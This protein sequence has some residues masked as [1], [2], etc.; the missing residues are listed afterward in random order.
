MKLFIILLFIHYTYASQCVTTTLCIPN[1]G[2]TSHCVGDST[3]TCNGCMDM[4]DNACLDP[5]MVG[6]S[7]AGFCDCNSGSGCSNGPAPGPSDAPPEPPPITINFDSSEYFVC[8]GETVNVNFDGLYNIYEVDLNNYNNYDYSFNSQH[9]IYSENGP[10]VY[11]I[12]N[13]GTTVGNTRYFICTL[14]PHRKFKTTCTAPPEPPP[15]DTCASLGC[16]NTQCR[17][18]NICLDRNPGENYCPEGLEDCGSGPTPEDTCASLGCSNTQCRSGNLC[19]DNMRLPDTNQCPEGLEDCGSGPSPGPPSETPS[20]T[21]SCSNFNECISDSDN[22]KNHCGANGCT[23]FLSSIGDC[24]A[25]C[26]SND[27]ESCQTVT[28]PPP[29]KKYTNEVCSGDT[30][31]YSG[32]CESFC[33]NNINETCYQHADPSDCASTLTC[34]L[35]T[36]SNYVCQD[37]RLPD[38]STCTEDSECLS[39]SCTPDNKCCSLNPSNTAECDCISSGS[40]WDGK[41]KLLVGSCS[42]PSDC[43]SNI[44]HLTQCVS[45]LPNNP[46]LLD[47]ATTCEL[48]Q[49][50]S[51]QTNYIEYR[52]AEKSYTLENGQFNDPSYAYPSFLNVYLIQVYQ[53]NVAMVQ[54]DATL[55]YIT[56]QTCNG[57]Y[58]VVQKKLPYYPTTLDILIDGLQVNNDYFRLN[59]IPC[60]DQL[61]TYVPSDTSIR[62]DGFFGNGHVSTSTPQKL[63][64]TDCPSYS[65]RP[66]GDLTDAETYCTCQTGY[67]AQNGQCEVCPAHSISVT[68]VLSTNTECTCNDGYVGSNCD[69]CPDHS[70]RT[71]TATEC[72]CNDNFIQ[73]G[74]NCVACPDGSV[75]TGDATSCTCPENYR[76][77]GNGCILCTDNSVRAAGD[78]P[79]TF[80]SCTCPENYYS[81]NSKCKPCEDGKINDA[82]DSINSN[83]VCDKCP[84]NTYF[85]GQCFDCPANSYS[86]GFDDLS[87][88]TFCTCNDG[89][90][91]EYDPSGTNKCVLCAGKVGVSLENADPCPLTCLTNQVRQGEG[92]N[93]CRANSDNLDQNDHCECKE[94][95]YAKIINGGTDWE[96]ASCTSLFGVNQAG[97]FAVFDNGYSTTS[98]CMC[99]ANKKAVNHGDVI[100]CQ[101]C[102]VNAMRDSLPF[103]DTTTPCLCPLDY[104]VSFG[105]CVSC[106]PNSERTQQDDPFGSDTLCTCK[107]TY[108]CQNSDCVDIGC[109]QCASGT[110]E[111]NLMQPTTCRCEENEYVSSNTCMSCPSTTLNPL[112]D[113]KGDDVYAGDTHCR[114]ENDKVWDGSSCVECP[115]NT[116]NSVHFDLDNMKATLGLA[117]TTRTCFCNENFYKETYIDATCNACPSHSTLGRGVGGKCVCDNGRYGADSCIQ[118]PTGSTISGSVIG[119]HTVSDCECLDNY[120]RQDGI[121]VPCP[122][123]STRTGDATQCSCPVNT[124]G[125]GSGCSACPTNMILSGGDP[126]SIE[127]CLC[128][129]DYYGQ[130]GECYSCDEVYKNSGIAAGSDPHGVGNHCTCRDGFVINYAAKNECNPALWYGPTGFFDISGNLDPSVDEPTTITCKQNHY[131]LYKGEACVV[132]A[133]LYPTPP[134]AGPEG[135]RTPGFQYACEKCEEDA[136]G[137]IKFI[138]SGKIDFTSTG[139]TCGHCNQRDYIC[140]ESLVNNKCLGTAV[141][142]Q[143]YLPLTP[144]VP[145]TNY[146]VDTTCYTIESTSGHPGL[147]LWNNNVFD[148]IARSRCFTEYNHKYTGSCIRCPNHMTNAIGS[149]TD[150][151]FHNKYFDGE[152]KDCPV[153]HQSPQVF[154]EAELGDLSSCTCK[155]GFVKSGSTCIACDGQIITEIQDGNPVD[156]CTCKP[157]HFVESGQCIHCPFNS[158]S[159]SIADPTGPDTTCDACLHKILCYRFMSSLGPV[160]K[161]IHYTHF[162][163]IPSWYVHGPSPP[164]INE[165]MNPIYANLKIEHNG[166]YKY[167]FDWMWELYAT[168]DNGAIDIFFN[169]KLS[170]ENALQILKPKVEHYMN[171]VEY[172]EMT[173]GIGC[174]LQQF[175]LSEEECRQKG[176]VLSSFGPPACYRNTVNGNYYYNPNLD[177][178]FPCMNAELN[179]LATYNMVCVC[180]NRYKLTRDYAWKLF[181]PYII[182]MNQ[183]SCLL[184]EMYCFDNLSERDIFVNLHLN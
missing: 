79:S 114:C 48:N 125:T 160:E 60:P 167:L 40:I 62:N 42:E 98:E 50:V 117:G 140:S 156:K 47:V 136:S 126:F 123:G 166:Q 132:D 6:G 115:S 101:D 152:I 32:I 70:T 57:N 113:G 151:Y 150:C 75:R 97:D 11:E 180:A 59:D 145:D 74:S 31:C 159:L 161:E 41:C 107:A 181:H 112:V 4:N 87:N 3:Y 171:Q 148:S 153:H 12:G 95:Y 8:T 154:S 174:P 122:D 182:T 108:F 178:N 137:F 10:G 90:T 54:T 82:G 100:S 24:L 58:N 106:K 43:I 102:P 128:A 44:C 143:R 138:E 63:K 37:L 139:T 35:D 131:V 157:N 66:A 81:K 71:G 51:L 120:V 168:G 45:E 72:T 91:S 38:S 13:L 127:T 183:N 73:S 163:S 22:N 175:S 25:A 55:I 2:V 67:K 94:N 135:C 20:V 80:R 173:S 164:L 179:T 104:Y 141:P 146:L 9:L 119:T 129:Q 85:N 26:F 93:D 142:A 76:S 130:D 105:Q 124:H 165:Y 36:Y 69:P 99:E 23:G 56:G 65:T 155:E 103:S 86:N 134:H 1:N 147:A 19:L 21:Y 14:H 118:C 16:S 158:F 83:T 116:F 89:Y 68:S 111:T 77:F 64:C 96:C 170:T 49:H 162:A 133:N 52:N 39:G 109:T 29:A 46:S 30:E 84:V 172:N 184:N 17:S 28:T 53:Q 169:S 121:C 61:E 27:C 34:A 7:C 144:G 88:P 149:T 33:K 110:P 92:C 177:S 18:G 5:A 78:D 176:A 15:G